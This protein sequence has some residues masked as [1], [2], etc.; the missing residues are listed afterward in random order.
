MREIRISKGG[1]RF[2][3]VYAPEPEELEKYERL[4]PVLMSAER[5]AAE[6]LDTE[7]VAHGFVADRSPVTCARSHIGFAVSLC[8]DLDSW[9][10]SIRPEQIE[11]GL[12]A[13]GTA[14]LVA[15]E[16]ATQVCHLGAPRQGLP[17]SP[18]A[19]NLAA[20]AMDR[21]ILDEL[22][23]LPCRWVY[24]RYADDLTVS[25]EWD[26]R[27][28]PHLCQRVLAV[29][30]AAAR[31]MG[32]AIAGRKTRTQHAHAG[33]RVIVGVSVGAEDVR[34]PK[35]TRKRLR[36]A[37]HQGKEREAR[38]L[39]EWCRMRLPR[40]L[41]RGWE[42]IAPVAAETVAA[43]AAHGFDLACPAQRAVYCDWLEEKGQDASSIRS[44]IAFS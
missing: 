15:H 34:A 12:I 10:D 22:A 9:F 41:R 4:L 5:R 29:L 28:A 24:T 26:A 1:G 3:T 44:T 17:T 11:A 32:W 38:G 30:S 21:R 2:R 40:A 31:R 43:A 13:G 33:R 36:A 23:G 16:L 20:V 8:C 6:A 25:L 42:I 37:R 18:A 27:D 7:A 14:P 19:A 35:R 39:A